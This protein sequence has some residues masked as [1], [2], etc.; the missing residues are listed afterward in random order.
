MA[1]SYHIFELRF[2]DLDNAESCPVIE[3]HCE[4]LNGALDLAA[5][6]WNDVLSRA[7]VDEFSS[8]DLGAMNLAIVHKGESPFTSRGTISRYA[9]GRVIKKTGACATAD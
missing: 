4:G 2:T 8:H 7:N 6:V 3:A 5:Y 1:S 9:D